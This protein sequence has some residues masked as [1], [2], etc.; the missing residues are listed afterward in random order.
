[1]TS[2]RKNKHDV[3][4]GNYLK[5]EK[6]GLWVCE[7]RFTD[8]TGRRTRKSVSATT[9]KRCIEKARELRDQLLLTS[10]YVSKEKITLKAF[11]ENWMITTQ[12]MVLKPTTYM[13]KEQV[14]RYQVY[15]Y[16]GHIPVNEL[17]LFSIQNMVN[18]LDNQGLT[19]SSIKKATDCIRQIVN[20]YCIVAKVDFNPLRG[21]QLPTR[22]RRSSSDIVF[23]SPEDCKKIIAAATALDKYG[24]P[25][26]R[27]G[28][29]IT[30]LIYTGMRVG[31]LLGMRWKD[32]DFENDLISVTGNAVSCKVKGKYVMVRQDSPKTNSGYRYIPLTPPA[33]EALKKL[34]EITGKKEYVMTNELG[35][36]FSYHHTNRMFHAI[37]KRCN[38]QV[39]KGT[40]VHSL[41][42]TFASLLFE[43]DTDVKTVSEILGHCETGITE[44]IYIHITNKRKALAMKNL[45]NF[46]E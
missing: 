44:D 37:L 16:V 46:L 31:E 35:N 3:I 9:K 15:P 17:N 23:F 1:M 10:P 32:V 22:K 43:H 6:K 45:G 2:K 21:V 33:K 36:I 27:L 14:L 39:P 4:V 29:A 13:R 30:V 20:Y 8:P 18:Q 12:K 38:I 42:H 26:Y 7:L 28:H 41:R 24:K 5:D 40:G 25:V 11:A 34:Y 19:Y